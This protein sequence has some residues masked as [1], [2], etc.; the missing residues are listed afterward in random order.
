VFRVEARNLY[1]TA[2]GQGAYSL[3]VLSALVSFLVGV[4]GWSCWPSAAVVGALI[5]WRLRRLAEQNRWLQKTVDERT[6]ELAGE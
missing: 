3:T 1:G 5:R 6:A 2:S 4:T